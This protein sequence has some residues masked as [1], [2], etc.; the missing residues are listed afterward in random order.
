M[1]KIISTLLLLTVCI[2]A[3]SQQIVT[4]IPTFID[5][6]DSA[7]VIVDLNQMDSSIAHVANL[8]TD[9]KAGLDMYIWTWNP[10]E[11]PA[12]HPYVN[13]LGSQAWKNSNPALKM[14]ALGNMKYQYTFKPTLLAWYS[15]DTTNAYSR[16]LS[17]LVKPLDGGGYGD[18][19]RKS[20]DINVPILRPGLNVSI[21]SHPAPFYFASN[22]SQIQINGECTINANLSIEVNGTQ[23]IQQNNTK[24]LSYTLDMNGYSPGTVEVILNASQGGNTAADTLTF[25]IRGNTPVQALPAGSKE[26]ISYPTNSSVLLQLRAPNKDFIY[27]IGDFN[28]WTPN[29]AYEM[30]KTPD[31]N[32]FWIEITGLTPGEQYRFQY[33]IDSV[34]LRVADPYSE[35][36]LDKWEDQWINN[37]TYPN[38]LAYPQAKTSDAVSVIQPGRT[39]Y[40]WDNSI[41]FQKPA[42]EELV[43]YELLIRD[44]DARH[45]FQSVIDRLDYLDKLGVNAIKLMPVMEFEGNNSWGYN[46]MFMF[47]VDKYYGTREKLK[48]LVDECHRRGMAVI[49][50]IVLNHQFGQSPLV[51]MYNVGGYGEPTPDNPWFNVTPKHDFNV[52]Y[53]MN[54]ESSST[55]YFSK[56]VFRYWVEEFKVDGF[57]LDLSKGFT[58]NNTLGNVGAWG[59]YDQSRVDI[60]QDYGNEVWS[61]DPNTYMILEH[62]ADNSEEIELSNRGFMLWGNLNHDYNEAM[63]GYGSNL[64]GAMASVRGWNNNYLVSYAESHDEERVMYKTLQ[65]GRVQGNYNIKQLSTALDRAEM[66]PVFLFSIPGP[67]MMWA[68]GELGYDVSIDDPC[69]ICEK[70]ILWNY[71]NEP[72]RRAVYRS[73]QMMIKLKTEHPAIFS[74]EPTVRGLNS[75]LKFLKYENNGD[76]LLVYG[77]FDANPTNVQPFFPLTGWWYDIATGDSLN[78]TDVNMSISYA[79]GEYHVYSNRKWFSAVDIP[80]GVEENLITNKVEGIRVGPNPFDDHL[81]FYMPDG[82]NI[83]EA[84]LTLLNS[85]GQVVYQGTHSVTNAQ[86]SWNADQLA[87]SQMYIYRVRAGN[88]IYTGRLLRKN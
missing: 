88:N 41:S 24:L 84:K 56:R 34:D 26:G 44:W 77:N 79:P 66:I 13:G 64:N 73:Y 32:Y 14:K 38:L 46:P 25:L 62:F 86:F 4:T 78:V 83:K 60:L 2:S 50:D 48:E 22:S 35:L 74:N 10:K 65:F 59:Q 49:L 29:P 30:K 57:R 80:I 51:R 85:L 43:C 55:R 81:N 68:H 54:H 69:R 61:I 21:V 11:H 53:D 39:P 27:V 6:N 16:G 23:V 40:A 12:G 36:I 70:A 19:D 71:L 52:G 72:D 15:T 76:H 33:S 75:F 9:A 58:Q 82:W 18:P 47:A 63:M 20:D 7:I 17:F 3:F 28:N 45:S 31:N 5:P 1:K 67:K 37:A 42:K 8:K 87:V